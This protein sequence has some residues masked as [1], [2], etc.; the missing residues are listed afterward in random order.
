MARRLRLKLPPW[1]FFVV[2][3]AIIAALL[4][5]L[6]SYRHRFVRSNSDLIRLLPPGDST[7]FFANFALL[8]QAGMM[9]MLSGAKPAEEK[10]YGEFVRQTQF[11][12]AKDIDAL[13]AAVDSNTDQIF[14]IGRGRFDWDKLR[15][16]VTAHGGECPSTE[17]CSIRTSR[18]GRW[19]SLMPIQPDVIALAISPDR[20]GVTLLRPPGHR[21]GQSVS[22]APVWMEVSPALLKNPADIPLPLRIFAITLQSAEPVIISLGPAE[23]NSQ[24]AFEIR[25]DAACPNPVT[26]DTIRNQLDLQTKLLKLE[27]TREHE[28]PNPA[29]LSG[30]L[31]A[32]SFQVVNRHVMGKWPVR[33][34]LLRALQQ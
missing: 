28:R 11:D 29:D 15:S 19:A 9:R 25:L 22:S 4:F 1:A 3:A 20:S 31:T 10:D 21:N 27:L 13:A 8:R 5:S 26:A 23:A 18:P 17:L 7:F 32:G 30:L 34:E 6:D 2:L 24:A 16:Y 12:Y 14:F 33:N